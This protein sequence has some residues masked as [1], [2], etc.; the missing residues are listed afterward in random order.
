[1]PLIEL[2]RQFLDMSLPLFSAK[3]REALGFS[4]DVTP[5]N[6]EVQ[7]KPFVYL[8]VRGAVTWFGVSR[9]KGSA[10]ARPMTGSAKQSSV[11]SG[12][13]LLLSGSGLLRR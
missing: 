12:S 9:A 10:N 8:N 13:G 11:V 5:L 2:M 6:C 7:F 1:M 3:L 4:G